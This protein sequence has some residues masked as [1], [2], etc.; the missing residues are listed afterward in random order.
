MYNTQEFIS[1]ALD[2]ILQQSVVPK[3]IFVVDDASTDES[4]QVVI[5]KYSANGKIK[6]LRNKINVGPFLNKNRV[7]RKLKEAYSYFA[8]LD[9][10]DFILHETFREMF[11]VVDRHQNV[12]VILPHMFR[13]TNGNIHEFK[14]SNT[15]CCFAGSLLRVDV[16]EDVGYFEPL[17]YGADGGFFYRC[18]QKFDAEGFVEIKK[19]LYRAEI[20]R[21]SLTNEE[22]YVNIDDTSEGYLSPDRQLYVDVF[23]RSIHDKITYTNTF[24][25]PKKMLAVPIFFV[26]KL[27]NECSAT[28]LFLNKNSQYQTLVSVDLIIEYI[29]LIGGNVFIDLNFQKTDM[30]DPT[31]LAF[32][33]I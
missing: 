21:K 28:G 31:W 29:Q 9:S 6:L 22:S 33:R 12:K 16:L 13:M 17:R 4:V 15:R 11:H 10:D 2:S 18:R 26:E 20:R 3:E 5:E 23:M 14:L 7:L 30:E 1:R 8:F 32:W 25:I 24:N 27:P 19:P